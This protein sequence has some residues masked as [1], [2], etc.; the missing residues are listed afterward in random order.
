VGSVIH[1]SIG[2]SIAPSVGSSIAPSVGSGTGP[3][4][5]SFVEG[6]AGGLAG[7]G[8]AFVG[9]ERAAALGP[10]QQDIGLPERAAAPLPGDR[11]TLL[12]EWLHIFRNRKTV[13]LT[14]NFEALGAPTRCRS[15]SHDA[16]GPPWAPT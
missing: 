16:R 1:L 4:W 12:V 7:A 5:G 2:S 3:R 11:T 8:L 13:A 6:G 9:G 15:I 10:C 14:A